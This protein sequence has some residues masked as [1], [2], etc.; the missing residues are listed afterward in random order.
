MTSKDLLKIQLLN[1]ELDLLEKSVQ[2]LQR[3][4]EKCTQ[5]GRKEQYS[6]E[7]LESFDSLTSK[8]GRT[9]DIYTQKVL[10]TTW[11]LLHE[12]FVPFI[13]LLNKAEKMALIQ[14]AD[15]LLEIRDLRNQ[16]AH[17]YIPEAITELIPEVIQK[18]PDLMANINQTNQFIAA[19]NWK[20]NRKEI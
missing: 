13:D 16:I 2:T 4:V 9:S 3:S 10:R 1:E 8:F 11:M 12:P 15:L 20:P 19:R 5:I 7:E 6:F 14:S 17:E 18:Q